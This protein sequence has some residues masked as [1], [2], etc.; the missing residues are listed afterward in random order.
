MKA[1]FEARIEDLSIRDRVKIE[2]QCGRVA[3]I[4]VQGLGLPAYEPIRE[5]AHKLRCENCGERGKVLLSIE[6]AN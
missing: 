2:C 5:L 1:L 3:L 6:W 4:A